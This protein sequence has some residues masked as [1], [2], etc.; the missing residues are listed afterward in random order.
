MPEETTTSLLEALRAGHDE[1]A[2]Q[3]FCQRYDPLLQ[4]FVRH[5][6]V[7]PDS[8]ADVVQ[9][10]RLAFVKAFRAGKYDPER[11]RLRAWLR[12]IA[13]NKVREAFRS[14]ARRGPQLTADSSSQGD[15]FQ[16]L[17]DEREMTDIF[18]REWERELLAECLRRVRQEVDERTFAAFRLFALEGWPAEQVAAHL[19]LARETVYVHKMRVLTRMRWLRVE[20]AESW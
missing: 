13:L 20:L 2:W 14:A 16:T 5:A 1:V 9:E 17:P 18:E 19:G 7:S 6:G 4:A 15:P 11:G 8:T 3:R 12:G 10:I